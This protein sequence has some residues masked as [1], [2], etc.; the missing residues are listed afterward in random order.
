MTNEECRHRYAHVAA[1]VPIHDNSTLCGY[2]NHVGTG[3][4]NGDSGN[5][6]LLKY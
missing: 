6:K 2:S 5:F 3:V 1:F 4:C